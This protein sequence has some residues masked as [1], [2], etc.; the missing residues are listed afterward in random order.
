[1][2]L[3]LKTL[4]LIGLVFL[5]LVAVLYVNVQHLLNQHIERAEKQNVDRDMQRVLHAIDVE[6]HHLARIADEYGWICA[7]AKQAASVDSASSTSLAGAAGP[8]DR[9]SVCRNFMHDNE[10]NRLVFVDPAGRAV[11][12]QSFD[13]ATGRFAAPTGADGTRFMDSIR[14]AATARLEVSATGGDIAAGN[15]QGLIALPEG[16]MLVAVHPVLTGDRRAGVLVLGRRINDVLAGRWREILN[17]DIRVMSFGEATGIDTE[18]LK[19][20]TERSA[21]SASRFLDAR[22][23]AGYRIIRDLANQP[24]LLLRIETPRPYYQ[25]GRIAGNY[26]IISNILTILFIGIFFMLLLEKMVLA[27]IATLSGQVRAIEES[28]DVSRRLPVRGRDELASLMGGIN[29]MLEGLERGQ[30]IWR[31][32][33]QRYHAVIRQAS[34]A[35]FL[36]DLAGGRILEANLA[37]CKLFGY[38]EA[39]LTRVD[40]ADLAGG[41]RQWV[42]QT[43]ARFAEGRGPG[44]EERRLRRKDGSELAAHVSANRISWDGRDVLCFVVHDITEIKRNEESLRKSEANFRGAFDHAPI[45]MAMVSLNGRFLQVNH[46]LC[47]ITGYGNDELLALNYRAFSDPEATLGDAQRVQCLLAGQ[48]ET[49]QYERR[50]L[51]KQGYP[52]WGLISVSVVRNRRGAPLYFLAQIQDITA[53]RTAEETSRS[54]QRFLHTIVDNIPDMVYVKDAATREYLSFNRAGEELLGVAKSDVIG[55]TDAE[56]FPEEV[57]R[58]LGAVDDVLL[59]SGRLQECRE[60]NLPSA[61]RGVRTVREKKLVITHEDG[62]PRYILGIA[63]DTTESKAI[64]EAFERLIRQ[65]DLILN[66][67]GEGIFGVDLDGRITFANPAAA[68]MLNRAIEELIGISFLADVRFQPECIQTGGGLAASPLGDGRIHHVN[69]ETFRRGDGSRFP[70]EYISAPILATGQ[71]LGAVVLFKDITDSRRVAEEKEALSTISQLIL[72]A[73][74]LES[75]YDELPRAI[76]AHLPIPAVR[77]MLWDE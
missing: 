77:I 53:R 7:G 54:M 10:L 18:P 15:V 21:H 76:V 2:T 6:C 56:I 49:I 39:D 62:S 22:H 13:P 63:E 55:R 45:G 3:R 11:F 12:D 26:V 17:I 28:A 33:Q 65:Q 42:G 59:A 57:A 37:F 16:P 70:V 35:I 24:D 34:E 9:S 19:Y 36:V 68:R 20:L 61:A 72:V 23:L 60:I 52:V 74:T 50:Y 67:A 58:P 41:D 44:G 1:M 32:N 75:I 48:C 27:P 8:L 40:F 14:R 30:R 64:Q 51:H 31:E 38:E 5:G 47:Q 29:G 43:F 4:L 25:Q 46:S 66:S 71:M 69:D 73:P